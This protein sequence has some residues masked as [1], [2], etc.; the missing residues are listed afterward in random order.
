MLFTSSMIIEPAQENKTAGKH[1]AVPK[2]K[3]APMPKA[4][5]QVTS[6]T[7]EF[8]PV[9]GNHNGQT[10][11]WAAE[12]ALAEVD[13]DCF[14]S[15]VDE[16]YEVMMNVT[17]DKVFADDVVESYEFAAKQLT[18]SPE[19]DSDLKEFVV[20]IA[21]QFA[22]TKEMM[23]TGK[24][25]VAWSVLRSELQAHL[26]A[27]NGHSPAGDSPSSDTAEIVEDS[28]PQ[29]G[30]YTGLRNALLVAL[31][32]SAPCVEAEALND[33]NNAHQ[34]DMTTVMTTL[35][36]C[37]DGAPHTSTIT[38]RFAKLAGKCSINM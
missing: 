15:L 28:P 33:I 1:T 22:W 10:G 19:Q 25:I 20:S 32:T 4:A 38:K 35:G 29:N 14:P 13:A 21:L 24:K 37:K 34:L 8:T 2:K 26:L 12:D 36:G 31:N 23:W 18:L 11:T 17:R 9:P 16:E 6:T 5:E 27:F 3:L 7:V 30:G